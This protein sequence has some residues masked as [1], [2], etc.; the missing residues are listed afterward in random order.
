MGRKKKKTVKPW[1]W[2]CNREFDDDKVLTFH[3]KAKHFK[4]HICHKKLF[5]APG[6]AIHCSQVHKETVSHVPNATI[7]RDNIEVEIFGMEGIPEADRIAHELRK[8]GRATNVDGQ[9]SK[10]PRLM[11]MAMGAPAPGMMY[12]VMAGMGPPGMMP[13]MPRMLPPPG[14]LMPQP[15]GQQPLLNN[16]PPRPL[17]PGGAPPP[18]EPP[19]Q[20]PGDLPKPTFPA[21]QNAPEQPPMGLPEGPPRQAEKVLP[22]GAGCKLMHPEDDL[23]LEE[24]RSELPQYKTGQTGSAPPRLPLP[25]S[26]APPFM[27]GG[28]P[29]IIRPGMAPMMGPPGT[30]RPG[31]A[32]PLILPSAVGGQGG[33]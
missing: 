19:A 23:S 21:Y 15:L 11:M 13:M 3:Q 16:I 7:G 22:V 6:L 30:I 14:P 24:V 1:C 9:D 33:W 26:A 10:R 8:T 4:C 29:P 5:S 12:P 28:G 18:S 17:F 31:F 27:G 20:G 25:N 32:P 2:Y